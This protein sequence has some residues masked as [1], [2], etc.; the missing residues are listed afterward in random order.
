MN[1]AKSPRR[2]R[3]LHI[4]LIAITLA[5]IPFYCWGIQTIRR[6][7]LLVLPTT[8][9]SQTPSHIPITTSPSPTRTPIPAYVTRTLTP[10]PPFFTPYTPTQTFT[11]EPTATNTLTPTP[12]NTPTETPTPITPSPTPDGG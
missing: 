11:P 12:T 8:T 7:P 5:T 3:R 1:N 9:P 10:L 4:V 6:A 2:I